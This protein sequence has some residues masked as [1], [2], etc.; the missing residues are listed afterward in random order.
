MDPTYF[1]NQID[2]LKERL[3]QLTDS[4]T[5]PRNVEQAFSK[6]LGTG[7]QEWNYLSKMSW[8]ASSTPQ[9]INNLS[10]D[11]IKLVFNIH[12]SASSVL[13]VTANLNGVTSGYDYTYFN[14]NSL[15]QSTN[16][17]SLL[18]CDGTIG[19]S[20][21]GNIVGEIIVNGK[22]SGGIKS[23]ASMVSA[24]NGTSIILANAS[25]NGDLNDLSS[26]TISP[27]NAITGQVEV[28]VKN[29]N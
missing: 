15:G 16:Q 2:T 13:K 23:V 3:D 8:T 11:Y 24:N 4:S 6:R 18:V 10:C 26:V 25:L 27:A 17:A 12:N 9:I 5:I 1:Q 28:W 14:G 19:G 20:A 29:N 21:G 7:N 22:H